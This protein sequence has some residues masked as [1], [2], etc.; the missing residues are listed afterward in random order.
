MTITDT[1]IMIDD[2]LTLWVSGEIDEL[3]AWEN[4]LETIERQNFDTTAK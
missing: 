2:L 3:E 4:V 1:L